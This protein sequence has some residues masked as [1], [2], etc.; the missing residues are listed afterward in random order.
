MLKRVRVGLIDSGV[1]GAP[2]AAVAATRVLTAATGDSIRHGGQ[3]ASCIL[4]HCSSAELLVAQVF[5]R[6]REA[7]VDAVVE[8]MHWLVDQGVQIINMSFGMA[9]PSARLASACRA[10]ARAG[11]VLVASAP[12]RGGVAFPAALEECI[13]VTGDARCAPGEVSWLATSAADFGTHPFCDPQRPDHGGGASMA[14]GRMS[15]LLA[16]LLEAEADADDVR[17]ELQRRAAYVGPE[18]RHA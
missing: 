5:G 16:G 4:Q 10:A 13:A 8:G 17:I 18:R 6:T 1:G 3:I 15:G 2:A 14:A 11:V 9:S 12:A 7:S